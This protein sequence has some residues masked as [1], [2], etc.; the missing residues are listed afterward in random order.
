MKSV[1]STGALLVFVAI[2]VAFP[3]CYRPP[4][5]LAFY[6]DAFIP[7]S[8]IQNDV[9]YVTCIVTGN[10]VSYDPG[11]STSFGSD[12]INLD[13]AWRNTQGREYASKRLVFT[14]HDHKITD[15][16]THAAPPYFVLDKKFYFTAKWKDHDG[17][18]S[19]TSGVIDC[20]VTKGTPT[21]DPE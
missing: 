4:G 2:L 12:P 3:G 7:D 8:G 13:V 10:A 9:R 6:V 20:R 14:H 17:E 18:H 19:W 1:G 15:T 11:L 21:L 16:I 5:V